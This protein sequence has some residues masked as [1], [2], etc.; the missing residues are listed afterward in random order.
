MIGGDGPTNIPSMGHLGAGPSSQRR[1]STQ[2]SA[3]SAAGAEPDS[4]SAY[5]K[6]LGSPPAPEE[7][8]TC[9]MVANRLIPAGTEVF[10]TYGEQLTNAQLLA[11]YGFALDGNENDTVGFSWADL[12][13]VSDVTTRR[14]PMDRAAFARSYQR[15]L[16]LFPSCELW[17]SSGLVYQ[18]DNAQFAGSAQ[19][20]PEGGL[21]RQDGARRGAVPMVINGDARVSHGLWLYCAVLAILDAAGTQGREPDTCEVAVAARRLARS[22]LL[23]ESRADGANSATSE[24]D[25]YDD[26]GRG[27]LPR[28]EGTT[29]EL[30]KDAKTL[31]TLARIV[32]WTC[33]QST[34][35]KRLGCRTPEAGALSTPQL[36]AQLDVS[37]FPALSSF[38]SNTLIAHPQ[39]TLPPRD[40]LFAFPVTPHARCLFVVFMPTAFLD[41]LRSRSSLQPPKAARLEDPDIASHDAIRPEHSVR[42][43]ACVSTSPGRRCA[44]HF[45]PR[46]RRQPSRTVRIFVLCTSCGTPRRTLA[47]PGTAVGEPAPSSVCTAGVGACR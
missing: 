24:A 6:E 33:T 8:D 32:A 3:A 29:G 23:F 18:P 34:R 12:P 46:T 9:D 36:A 42:A 31:A 28:Y 27:D 10:N 19:A 5:A 43:R 45:H 20:E 22:Q 37:L 41:I 16:V 14:L 40:F 2:A 30:D 25:A 7:A 47:C 13:A 35:A 21:E 38:L 44:G 39:P 26:E 4:G 11:R 17:D 1:R 15:T